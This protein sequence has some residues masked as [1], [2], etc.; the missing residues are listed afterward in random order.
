M[1]AVIQ[2]GPGKASV[3]SVPVPCVDRGSVLIKVEAVLVHP[4]LQAVFNASLPHFRLPYPIIP[5]SN[6]I[7][8]VT[9]P[10]PDTTIL[11]EG[12]LV[13][14]NTFVRAR[15]DPSVGVVWGITPGV[16]P[17]ANHLYASTL[18]N[19]VCAEYVLAPLENTFA[20]D[21]TRLLGDLA[22][23]GL[24][25]SIPDLLQ[26]APD[27]IL[28]G[29]LRSI[30]LQAGERI[31]VTPA[32]GHFSA[33][34]VDVAIAMGAEVV[35]ASRNAIGLAKLKKIHPGVN[36]V[37]LTGDLET[38]SKALAGFGVIDA[39]ID[40]SPPAATGSNN[41]T[42][43]VSTLRP[44]GRVSLVGGR[45]DESLPIPYM[46]AMLKSLKIQAMYMFRREDQRGL[47]RLA[48]SGLLTLGEAKGHTIDAVYGLDGLLEALDKAVETS[49]PGSIVYIKP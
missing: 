45:M 17:Q 12:Q 27:T 49:G 35:A 48:E 38:D 31:I 8:R 41:I 22:C 36:T 33:A 40:I 10:G 11:K 13:I 47:I 18:L 5:G 43:A 24:G 26:L 20:L 4:N 34:A 14:V 16:T 7:G 44:F 39:I 1:R 25:Y 42:A 15:D 46:D 2:T 30:S 3:E 28:Y 32:T 21:E 29:A 9:T 23:G 6:A 19:G 37:Q